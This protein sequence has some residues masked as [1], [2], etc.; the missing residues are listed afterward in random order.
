MTNT[1]LSDAEVLERFSR[2]VAASLHIDAS[3]VTPDAHLDDLGAESLDLIEITMETEAQFNIYLPDKSILDT[4]VEVF[5]P[6]VLEK[7]GYLTEEG[8]R[9][10]LARL[11]EADADAFA[12]QVAVK[13]LKRYFMKIGTWVRMIQGLAQHT[14]QACAACG[15]G[16]VPSLGFRVKCSACGD[17]VTLRSGEEL[18][19]EWVRDY[20]QRHFQPR[21]AGTAA[22]AAAQL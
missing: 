22:A 5:G 4:A 12:G 21:T 7:D 3:K 13:D 17:E 8:K 6:G 9:L 15:G 2:V 18:N 1:Y 16:M 11:P 20:Y 14:P 10:M 19:R